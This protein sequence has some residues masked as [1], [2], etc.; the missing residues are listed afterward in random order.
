[1]SNDIAGRLDAVQYAK[2]RSHKTIG[3]TDMTR[4]LLSGLLLGVVLTGA[5]YA[6]ETGC[7]CGSARGLPFTFVHPYVICSTSSR[8]VIGADRDQNRFGSVLDLE[9]LGY[10]LFTWGAVGFYV[11]RHFSRRK[12]AQGISPQNG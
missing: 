2:E 9:S 6:F 10:D 12:K 3:R 7:S 4:H 11:A 5:S 1:M 8:L